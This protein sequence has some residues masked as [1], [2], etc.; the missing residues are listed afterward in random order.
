MVTLGDKQVDNEYTCNAMMGY[1][2]YADVVNAVVSGVD[3]N[4]AEAKGLTALHRACSQGRD[5]QTRWLI[6]MG[7]NV[8]ERAYWSSNGSTPLIETVIGYGSSACMQLLLEA[9]A[10][11]DIKVD[12]ALPLV[13]FSMFCQE[14]GHPCFEILLGCPNTELIFY[15]GKSAEA[16]AIEHG[17]YVLA[18]RIAKEA[19]SRRR[20]S[21]LRATWVQALCSWPPAAHIR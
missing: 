1:L 8:N 15:S 6:S 11:V 2:Q 14:Q 19:K 10:E 4:P 16:F 18:R 3:V 9:G 5:A 7:A 21:Q 17:R 13:A 12:S 20:W